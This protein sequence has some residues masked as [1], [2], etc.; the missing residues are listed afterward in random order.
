MILNDDA[1]VSVSLTAGSLPDE[2]LHSFVITRSG[3]TTG[4]HSVSYSIAPAG[5]LGQ[6]NLASVLSSALSGTVTF[7]PGQTE[8][9]VNV[10]R[11][12]AALIG[13]YQT[14]ALH[15]TTD[16]GSNV[17]LVN[18]TAQSSLIPNQ[19]DITLK[20]DLDRILEGTA[21]NSA[22]EFV[23]IVT[24]SGR[25]DLAAD[26]LWSIMGHGDSPASADDFPQGLFPS[27]TA[28]FA[29][30]ATT[31]AI[32]FSPAPDNNLDGEEGFL[33]QLASANPAIR[34]L[35]QSIEGVIVDDESAVG[36]DSAIPFAVTEGDSGTSVLIA[37]AVRIGFAGAESSVQWR[38]TQGDANLADFALGQDILGDNNGYPSGTLTLLP[39]EISAI[40]RIRIAT[41]WALENA[42]VFEITLSQPS[43]NTKVIGQDVLF[44]G[45]AQTAFA[46]IEND[47]SVLSMKQDSYSVTEGDGGSSA[48]MAITVVREGSTVGSDWVNWNLSS[49][50]S[51]PADGA[52]I[53]NATSGLSIFNSP[54]Q[55]WITLS[56]ISGV[57]A[58]S[59]SIDL[60]R[61]GYLM[62]AYNRGQSYTD[63]EGINLPFDRFLLNALSVTGDASLTILGDVTQ[64][65][66][67]ADE[68]ALDR[69]SGTLFTSQDGY[70]LPNLVTGGNKIV[71]TSDDHMGGLSL[72]VTGLDVNGD[73]ISET[74]FGPNQG[75]VSTS[76]RFA[77]VLSVEAVETQFDLGRLYQAR[78]MTEPD[79]YDVN[80]GDSIDV[81][82]N[83]SVSTLGAQYFD[84]WRDIANADVSNTDEPF[85]LTIRTEADLTGSQLIVYGGMTVAMFDRGF[86]EF[87][88]M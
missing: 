41:D 67:I 15:L 68:V 48:M 45:Y 52:D 80:D 3:A 87:T 35:D 54:N 81:I 82:V 72:R 7:T 59:G 79:F 49:K 20:A 16:E 17:S 63:P 43:P 6:D 28:H 9:T 64:Q 76:G 25:T 21:A 14:F 69:F 75:A 85:Q 13:S 55:S 73:T 22:G 62:V 53:G 31:A 27:G 56:Q 8:K 33:L 24:R 58:E 18:A 29:Q 1:N 61:S 70:S 84:H 36:F 34:L 12:A 51:A 26:I 2:V 78:S 88:T 19:Q 39:G 46:T 4:T 50:G 57:A 74:I 10:T 66:F 71:I 42:E 30:G 40:A 5:E 83:G 37:K 11:A 23:Y 32:R 38:V 60:P 47:D 65:N 77:S 44:A 86:Y